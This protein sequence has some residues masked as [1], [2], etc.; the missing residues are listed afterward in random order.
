MTEK[1]AD[2]NKFVLCSNCFVD[3]G[4]RIDS[5]KHGIEQQGNCPNCNSSDGKKLTRE[6]VLG[7]ADRFFVNGTTVRFDYGAAPAVVCNEH[8]YGKSDISPSA[9][10][11]NDLKLIEDA[12]RIGFFHYGPRFWMFG[13]IEP[14]KALQDPATR[15][16]VVERVLKEYPER[17]LAKD[18]KFYR[19]RVN[20][21]RPAEPDEYD[22]P[23]TH[24]AGKGRLDF[25]G[26]SVMYGSQDLDICIHECR[27]TAE[28]EMYVATLRPNRDLRLLDLTAVLREDVTEFESLDLAIHMLFLAKSHSYEISR[29]IAKAVRG[30]GLDGLIY[31]SYFSLLRTGGRPFETAYGLSIRRFHPQ[32]E[33]YAATYTI[34]NFALFGRPIEQN[35]VSVK[36]IN[37]MILT[38]V[39]YAGHFGPVAY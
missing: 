23:P 4:L 24:V 3:E 9:W 15:S 12:G 34:P 6:H 39:G 29:E 27:A 13:E 32:A 10:L 8:H 7:L 31:P 5:W 30:I 35:T 36:C 20:P 17:I 18:T 38:Q 19:V 28:D 37:R 14:L 25:V 21:L 16:P 33:Q 1:A 22:S 26:F 11:R 2:A